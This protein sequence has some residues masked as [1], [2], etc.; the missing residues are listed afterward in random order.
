MNRR[1]QSRNVEPAAK[2]GIL[3]TFRFGC[4]IL[5]RWYFWKPASTL[6]ARISLRLWGASVGEGL[7]VRGRLRVHNEGR[8][9]IGR[10]VTINSGPA[11]FVGGERR[12]AMWVGRQGALSI[13]DGCRLSNTTIVCLN[14]VTFLPHTFIG[15]GCGIYDTDFHHLDAE[16]RIAGRG[17]VPGGPIRIGPKAFIGGHVIVLKNVTIGEGAVVGAG[18]VVTRSIPPYQIWAGVPAR[19]IRKMDLAGGGAGCPDAEAGTNPCEC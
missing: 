17:G 12:M 16:D 3:Q 15:G 19:F 10:D 8:L 14:G 13:Q 9:T 5:Y 18:S 6:Y 2:R 7:V 11:N 1:E 4:S